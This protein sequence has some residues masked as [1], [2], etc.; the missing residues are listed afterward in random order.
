VLFLSLISLR[1]VSHS[2]IYPQVFNRPQ[3]K[4]A[5]NAHTARSC[6]FDTP[7]MHTRHLRLGKTVRAAAGRFLY[8]M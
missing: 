1:G 5:V 4:A 3:V 8:K 6:A 2:G 7:Q